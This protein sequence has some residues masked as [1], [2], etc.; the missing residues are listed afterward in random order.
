[1]FIYAKLKKKRL[2]ETSLQMKIEFFN[3]YLWIFSYDGG[4]INTFK[5]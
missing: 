4:H 5:I 3:V 2:L 1:M